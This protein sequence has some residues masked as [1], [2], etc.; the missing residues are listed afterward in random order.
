MMVWIWLFIAVIAAIVVA[1]I[2]YD[3]LFSSSK[4]NRKPWFAVLRA[5][6]V[7]CVLLLFIS[8]KFESQSYKTIRPQLV[9]MTDNSQ[10][11][12]NL[13]ASNPLEIDL[14]QIRTDPDLNERFEIVTYQFAEDISLSDS[15]NF[16]GTATNI[17]N[18]I[19]QPQELLRGRNK[20]IV[21][22]T[23]GN[24]TLGKNYR[25]TSLDRNSH[26]Y[27]IVYGDTTRYPDLRI[28]QVNV[29]RYSY[30]NNEYPVEVFVSYT[31]QAAVSTNFKITNGNAVLH[32][33]RLEFDADKTSAVIN[34]QLKSNSIGLQ[35]MVAQVDP[36]TSEKN[37]TNNRR[38]FAVEVIDQQSKILILSNIVH[39]DIAALKKAIES[40]RQRS[41]D[42]MKTTD[43]YDINDYNLV[44]MFGLDSA[45]AKAY[46]TIKTLQKNTWLILG[47]KPDLGFLNRTTAAFQIENYPQRDDVQPILNDAYPNFN[48]ESFDFEDYPPV[49]APFGQITARES[50]SVLMYKQIGSVTTDQPLWFTYEDGTSKHA[51]FT[52][53]G[54]WRWRSQSYLQEKDFRNF[55]DLINSQ[56]QFL[57]SNKKRDRLDVDSRTFYFENDRILISAQYLNQ[58]Y[59]FI[60]DGVLNMQLSNDET[61][62]QLVRPFVLSN[63]TYQVDLSGLPAGDYSYTVEAA[64]ENLR[65]SGAFSILEFNIEKQFVNAD[66]QSLQSIAT[67]RQIFY[68]KETEKLKTKLL[69]DTLLQDVER[70]ETTYESLIDWKVLLAIILLL[71]SAEWFLR[72]YNGLI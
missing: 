40:N 29:N 6:T 23:D 63:N 61:N 42:I 56:I 28:N 25:Y 53:S 44:I 58:N 2:Q 12:E 5:I 8:P 48:L 47:P 72:K 10:S 30:L 50:L 52:G 14:E 11:I 67:D 16:N 39:P 26:L 34:V 57:A 9:L 43:A 64:N 62:E 69:S 54:L 49:T 35:I 51:V 21:L 7:F 60:S 13:E 37:I 20:A 19:D 68:G 59:E 18:A 27:P 55:D 70:S 17:A 31:G 22:M 3:Y 36:I 4:K 24:Q 33:Q 65:R 41:V 15:L 66:Y 38:D 32:Q 71:L 45:F 46:S 1:L